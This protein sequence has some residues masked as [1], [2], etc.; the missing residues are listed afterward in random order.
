MFEGPKIF[1]C[2]P[3]CGKEYYMGVHGSALL[4]L[5]SMRSLGILQCRGFL[6]ELVYMHVSH[7]YMYHIMTSMLRQVDGS[8]YFKRWEIVIA[9]DLIRNGVSY[10]VLTKSLYGVPLSGVFKLRADSNDLAS[11]QVLC[12]CMRAEW[13]PTLS[14]QL[15]LKTNSLTVPPQNKNEE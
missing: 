1:S 15:S 2:A 14:Q 4:C 5:C 3:A 7:C 11:L 13:M 6:L 10:K 9:D 8:T 12:Q